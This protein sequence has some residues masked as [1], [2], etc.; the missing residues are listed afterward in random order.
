[1]SENKQNDYVPMI[2]KTIYGLE[3]ILVKELQELGASDIE[4]QNRVVTFSGN[5]KFLY[6][7]NVHLRTAGRI[8]VPLSQFTISSKDDYYDEI[9]K[10]NWMSLFGLDETFAIDALVN[11]S[12]AF[13]NSMYAGQLA[14]DAIVDQFREETGARPSVDTN[15]PDIQINIHVN[16][17]IITVSLDS[18]GVPLHKRG[19]RVELS[20]A[21]MNENL[22]AGLLLIAGYDG[23]QALIDPM[24][25]SGTIPIEAAMIA[26]NMAPSLY[27]KHFAF[28]NW[29]NFDEELFDEVIAE[30]KAEVKDELKFPIVGSDKDKYVIDK[31]KNN[32]S[33]VRLHNKIIFEKMR[34][35]NQFPPEED[36][37]LITNP[38]YGERLD[39]PAI[40]SLYSMIGDTLKQNF[41]GY[42]AF[43]FSGNLEAVKFVGLKPSMKRK[44]FNGPIECR[45][46]RYEMYKG[47]KKVS[48]PPD[49]TEE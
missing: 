7:A 49:S 13:D 16:K 8:L 5:K 22:A 6:K 24:C 23:E 30:A 40:D 4:A 34:F 47:S 43:I 41:D 20:K 9:K 11:H 27:R 37:M 26:L 1:M 3:E 38:P 2:A 29:N 10:I 14:K 28:M 48:T 19:Y 12:R 35:E 31:A 17:N 25:G 45:F 15:D 32:A 42:D 33:R 18:S 36:G 44:M 46:L 39:I 21:P